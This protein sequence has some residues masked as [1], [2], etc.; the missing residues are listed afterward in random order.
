MNQIL[1]Y[2]RYLIYKFNLSKKDQKRIKNI[3]KFYKEKLTSKTFNEN[4]LNSIFYYKGKQALIDILYFKLFKSKKFDNHLI[5][6]TK[7]FKEKSIPI[8]PIKADFLM[9]KYKIPEGKILGNKLKLIEDIWVKN[10]FRISD[11][12]VDNIINN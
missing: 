6:L 4:N 10:N 7:L 3:D 12:E 11:N 2:L 5:E 1:L 9:S 8:M